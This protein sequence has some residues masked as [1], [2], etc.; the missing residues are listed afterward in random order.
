MSLTDKSPMPFGKHAGTPMEKVPA[1]Y[2]LWLADEMGSFPT[3]RNKALVRR[4]VDENRVALESE[5]SHDDDDA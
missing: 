4:Y 5:V 1:Q 2:L 3:A